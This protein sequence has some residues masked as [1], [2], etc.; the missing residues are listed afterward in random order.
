MEIEELHTLAEEVNMLDHS[1]CRS[2]NN[3]EHCLA[4]RS[5]AAAREAGMTKPCKNCGGCALCRIWVSNQLK[6]MEDVRILTTRGRVDR[7]EFC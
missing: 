6:P 7:G 2:C 1:F 5:L 3:R 4:V